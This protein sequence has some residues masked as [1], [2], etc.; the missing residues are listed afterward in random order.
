MALEEIVLRINESKERMQELWNKREK[1][2]EEI[3][4]VADEIDQ[5][6]LEHDRLLNYR[7]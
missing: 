1:V 2:N 5:L 6:L 4:R 3:L 7:R